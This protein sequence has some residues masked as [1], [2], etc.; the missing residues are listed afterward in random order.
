MSQALNFYQQIDGDTDGINEAEE[1]I[2]SSKDENSKQIV[3]P[4]KQRNMKYQNEM[5]RLYQ[6]LDW[7]CHI[8]SVFCL[9]CQQID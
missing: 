7:Q 2:Y 3:K 6:Y 5:E 4:E 1:I 9:G 8:C